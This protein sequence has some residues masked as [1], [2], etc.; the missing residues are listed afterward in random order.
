MCVQ[1]EER[2]TGA[3]GSNSKKKVGSD[4][5]ARSMELS[6]VPGDGIRHVSGV[7]IRRR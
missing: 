1:E 4:A 6:Y 7:V 2:R 5:W 3:R